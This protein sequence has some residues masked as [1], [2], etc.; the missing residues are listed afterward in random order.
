MLT[1]NP[2]DDLD[3]KIQIKY[4]EICEN[5]SIDKIDADISWENYKKVRNDH[6][7]DVSKKNIASFFF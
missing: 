1:N 3:E 4:N 2:N 5:L 6:T 7:L